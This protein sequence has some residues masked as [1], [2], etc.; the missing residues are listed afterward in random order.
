M[1]IT[2]FKNSVSCLLL[3]ASVSK[4]V[5]QVTAQRSTICTPNSAE[6]GNYSIARVIEND[7]TALG[8]FNTVGGG[9]NNHADIEDHTVVGGGVNNTANGEH[10]VISGGFQSYINVG[11]DHS[12][13]NGGRRHN[14]KQPGETLD[15]YEFD[16]PGSVI[17]GG[18]QN[19]W[20]GA[21]TDMTISGG[22]R[23]LISGRTAVITG[24]VDNAASGL[25]SVVLGGR[26]NV[27]SGSFSAIP[28][29]TE[30]LAAGDYSVAMGQKA[31]AIF[32][33]SMAINMQGKNFALETTEVGQFLVQAQTYRLQLT[34]QPGKR[35]ANVIA[36]D[37][38]NI[39]NLQ[40]AIDSSGG[41]RR[42]LR[43]HIVEHTRKLNERRR[44][45]MLAEEKGGASMK[46]GARKVTA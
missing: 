7:N 45:R 27:A 39:G 25:N 3:A 4:V 30:N 9:L 28:G 36:I 8:D 41:R 13:I 17:T 14:M 5:V 32:D 15:F 46:G 37:A 26:Y 10:A 40:A 11:S 34:N 16:A 1:A 20:N 38:T 29:G 2:K 43:P 22:Q 21:E 23:N 12:T 44:L 42:E 24:G 31:K 19:A 18:I 35:D 6:C 33:N